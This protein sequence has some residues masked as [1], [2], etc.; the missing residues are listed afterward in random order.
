MTWSPELVVGVEL[1][2]QSTEELRKP[3]PELSTAD[4]SLGSSKMTSAASLILFTVESK[5]IDDVTTLLY[6]HTCI[7]VC[8]GPDKNKTCMCHHHLNQNSHE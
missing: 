8:M 7:T 6:T 5:I 3:G 1:T 2:T 4:E